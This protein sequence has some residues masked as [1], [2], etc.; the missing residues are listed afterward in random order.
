MAINIIHLTLI[1]HNLNVWQIVDSN[2]GA[3]PTQLS[4]KVLHKI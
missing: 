2:I 3:L 1:K 4:T